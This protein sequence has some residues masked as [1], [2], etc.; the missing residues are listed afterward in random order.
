MAT[1]EEVLAHILHTIASSTFTSCLEICHDGSVNV[2]RGASENSRGD[3]QVQP[4]P[5]HD[6]SHLRKD[7]H[8]L[9]SQFGGVANN[10]AGMQEIME[11]MTNILEIPNEKRQ[12]YEDSMVWSAGLKLIHHV[13]NDSD[14]KLVKLTDDMVEPHILLSTI[15]DSYYHNDGDDQADDTRYDYHVNAPQLSTPQAMFVLR[16]FLIT[17]AIERSVQ[18]THTALEYS[19]TIRWRRLKSMLDDSILLFKKMFMDQL[20]CSRDMDST[21]LTQHVILIGTNIYV[22]NIFPTARVLLQ[23]LLE[24]TSDVA[25]VTR[26]LQ[27]SYDFFGMLTSLASLGFVFGED[28]LSSDM[29][30]MIMECIHDQK[31]DSLFHLMN[32]KNTFD[33]IE[34]GERERKRCCL[35]QNDSVNRGSYFSE[36]LLFYSYVQ[37]TNEVQKN[38]IGL[39]DDLANDDDSFQSSEDDDCVNYDTFGVAVIAQALTLPLIYSREYLW[40]L[41]FPHVHAFL[42][43]LINTSSTLNVI[44]ENQFDETAAINTGLAMLENLMS[45]AP[46]IIGSYENAFTPDS[47]ANESPISVVICTMTLAATIESLLSTVMRLSMF[48]A[49]NLNG[50]DS[51]RIMYSSRQVMIMTQSL[52]ELH[53]PIIRVHSLS[54]L[55]Q[56][57]KFME[58]NKVLLPRVLDWVRSAVMKICIDMHQRLNYGIDV[59]LAVADTVTPFLQE[60][61]FIFDKTKPPLP[62]FIPEFMSNVESYISTLSVFR[63][64]RMWAHRV[65][66]ISTNKDENDSFHHINQWLL[67]YEAIVANFSELL[68]DLIDF[69]TRACSPRDAKVCVGEDM[70]PPVGWHRLNLLL[71]AVEESLCKFGR[72]SR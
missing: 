30:K 8:W 38:N 40:F 15:M 52:L 62:K 42:S 22:N 14:I 25:F 67:Q 28:G 27:S 59:I 32:D 49:S 7:L 35:L 6:V 26:I 48:E 21:D 44:N 63:A 45:D 18:S 68:V 13:V 65:E 37:R 20:D 23:L 5:T 41:L 2:L 69:W 9:T 61:E 47:S 51:K 57:M 54:S 19:K 70:D 12:C 1:R 33:R 17:A 50:A 53:E 56:K 64:I 55:S 72:I 60:L 36:D 29:T 71:H 4:S 39:T 43:G 16:S 10:D 31:T 3:V 58:H 11:L 24:N 66:T 46:S 34:D